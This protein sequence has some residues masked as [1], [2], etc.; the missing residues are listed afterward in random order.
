M[1]DAI[2]R[3]EPTKSDADKAADYRARIR[4]LLEQACEI[5]SEARRNG[6]GIGFNLAPDQFG[7]QRVGDISVTKPL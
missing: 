3:L 4:P 5:I 1:N 6:L 7:I 2:A